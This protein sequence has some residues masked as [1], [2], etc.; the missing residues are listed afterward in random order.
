MPPFKLQGERVRKKEVRALILLSNAFN[1]VNSIV[2][3]DHKAGIVY[4]HNPNDEKAEPKNF[5]FDHV[6]DWT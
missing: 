3:M 6:W 2:R 4:V 5:L 1:T